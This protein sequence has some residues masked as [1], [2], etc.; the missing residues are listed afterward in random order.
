MSFTDKILKL[1]KTRKERAEEIFPFFSKGLN[2]EF[3]CRMVSSKDM[4]IA[5]E[6]CKKHFKHIEDTT[7]HVAASIICLS[8]GKKELPLN[9]ENVLALAEEH[10]K[11]ILEIQRHIT[12][13]SGLPDYTRLAFQELVSRF[14]PE[15]GK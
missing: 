4:A 1:K 6:F 8:V 3:N 9:K 14:I 10:E 2:L 11:F 5:A 15:E 12:S 13:I 7:L